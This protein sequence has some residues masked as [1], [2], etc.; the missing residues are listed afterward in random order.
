MVGL[1]V[2]DGVYMW[3][4]KGIDAGLFSRTLMSAAHSEVE[5]GNGDALAGAQRGACFGVIQERR[6]VVH[7]HAVPQVIC[8]ALLMCGSYLQACSRAGCIQC[9]CK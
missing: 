9:M 7:E 8:R 3:K 4:T 6:S 1:G 2:A 5:G